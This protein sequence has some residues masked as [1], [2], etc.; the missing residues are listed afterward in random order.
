MRKATVIKRF[1]RSVIGITFSVRKHIEWETDCCE[2]IHYSTTTDGEGDIAFRK[3]FISRCPIAANYSDALISLLHEIGHIVMDEESDGMS[4]GVVCDTYEEY[5]AMH[6]EMIA[7]NWAID[8]LNNKANEKL[9]KDFE[10]K[11][12]TAK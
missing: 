4:V 11:W 9:A 10:E 6:D 2:F 12:L 8:W 3:N 7:T 1:C 5:F